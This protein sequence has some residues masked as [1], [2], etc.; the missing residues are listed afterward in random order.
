LHDRE[1][2]E[3]TAKWVKSAGNFKEDNF[4]WYLQQF[5]P[6]SCLDPEFT[7]IKPFSKEEMENFLGV[8]KKHFSKVFLRG[9]Y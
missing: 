8:F 5:R 2:L 1:G 9:V 7:K 6:T 3:K 4:S